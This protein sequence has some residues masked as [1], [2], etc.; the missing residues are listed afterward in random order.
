MDQE[1]IIKNIKLNLSNSIMFVNQHGEKQVLDRDR[2]VNI[3]MND[4]ITLDGLVYHKRKALIIAIQNVLSQLDNLFNEK[5]A[6]YFNTKYK[7]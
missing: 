1:T 3:L 7:Q 6:S 4:I 5:K 2:W